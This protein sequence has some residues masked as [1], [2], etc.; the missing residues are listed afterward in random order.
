LIILTSRD[1][2]RSARS[3][4]DRGGNDEDPK[5]VEKSDLLIRARKRSKGRRAKEEIG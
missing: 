5:S 1:L 3:G 2:H 4:R